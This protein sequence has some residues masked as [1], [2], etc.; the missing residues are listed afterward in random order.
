MGLIP[1]L[2]DFQLE[3]GGDGE[4][5]DPDSLDVWCTSNEFIDIM[6]G[7]WEEVCQAVFLLVLSL[8]APAF[9]VFRF[10]MKPAI[11]P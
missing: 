6:A 10:A 3:G 8:E 7:D 2:D 9:P 4:D 11:P 1:F 5:V